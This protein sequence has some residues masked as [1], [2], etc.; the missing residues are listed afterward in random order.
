M[1]PPEHLHQTKQRLPAAPTGPT[2]GVHV[3]WANHGVKHSFTFVAPFS[4]QLHFHKAP[5]LP[6]LSTEA[7][8]QLLAWIAREP[9][10]PA[11]SFGP[12]PTLCSC[13]YWMTVYSAAVCCLFFI[14]PSSFP[15]KIKAE[16]S[17][18]SAWQMSKIYESK[19]ASFSQ[20]YCIFSPLHQNTP[21]GAS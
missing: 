15:L 3:D 13:F 16:G 19:H 6:P 8:R 12:Q 1:R 2:C 9:S 5:L 7:T 21:P 14:P 10:D 4:L 20:S 17:T 18:L 11:G